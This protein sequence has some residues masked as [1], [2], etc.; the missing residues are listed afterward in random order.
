[1]IALSL[2]SGDYGSDEEFELA[3][4]VAGSLG[5]RAIRDARTLTAVASAETPQFAKRKVYAVRELST[6]SRSRLLDD[7]AAVEHSEAAL[8]MT[9]VARVTGDD[10]AGVSVAF[11][12]CGSGV[13]AREL[14]VAS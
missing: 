5:A 1:V 2:A 10:S 3:V 12:V 11:L 14:R 9:D 8:G 6:L 7:L 13:S 4:S